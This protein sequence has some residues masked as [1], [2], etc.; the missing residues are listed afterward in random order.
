VSDIKPIDRSPVK[1]L[2]GLLGKLIPGNYNTYGESFLWKISRSFW[3]DDFSDLESIE[4]EF[5]H[6][7][8]SVVCQIQEVWGIPDFRGNYKTS[9][10]PQW[11]WVWAEKMSYW[12]REE[13]IAFVSFHRDDK[14]L[15]YEIT[16]GA[17]SEES[18]KEIDEL[19]L[20]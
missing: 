15:P 10:Y 6:E 13:G 5:S 11:Y 7:Y 14:E 12:T 19:G 17:I 16:F 1:L 9:D 20:I 18:I 3:D 2:E 4:A 8:E